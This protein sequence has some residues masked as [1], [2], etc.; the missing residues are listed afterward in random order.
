MSNR[1]HYNAQGGRMEKR[2]GTKEALA[3]L[4]LGIGVG[5]ATAMLVA[6]NDGNGMRDLVRNAMEEG[7]QR[8]RDAATHT[9]SQ[10]EGEFPNLRKRVDD[11]FDRVTN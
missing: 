2:R 4:T 7:Y 11:L 10:L 6:P 3:F 8:G 1:I 9:L 5:A